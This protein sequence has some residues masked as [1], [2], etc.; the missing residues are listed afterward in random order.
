MKNKQQEGDPTERST[1]P[2]LLSRQ[3][4]RRVRSVPPSIH[5]SHSLPPRFGKLPLLK[6]KN[7]IL[8]YYVSLTRIFPLEIAV[9]N[10]WGSEET[11]KSHECL[12]K[13]AHNTECK[14]CISS[15]TLNTLD[16]YSLGKIT[17][18]KWRNWWGNFL[19]L[20]LDD[21]DASA[22]DDDNCS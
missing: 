10:K 19:D 16:R 2:S 1:E 20:S 18:S 8:P 7:L 13:L 14:R 22:T 17:N 12:C 9:C 5:R 21:I 4:H 15:S 6:M 11:R 3:H